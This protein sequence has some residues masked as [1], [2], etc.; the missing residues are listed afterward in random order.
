MGH[1]HFWLLNEVD[2]RTEGLDLP[3]EADREAWLV[4]D[5]LLA[6]CR[7]VEIWNERELIGRIGAAP[8]A[9]V[10]GLDFVWPAKPVKRR[11]RAQAP[12]KPRRRPA[13]DRKR[14]QRA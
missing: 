1:Y 14:H 12:A 7:S 2:E 10:D 9:V 5:R 6:E 11:G 4:A 3:C 13:P 8:V